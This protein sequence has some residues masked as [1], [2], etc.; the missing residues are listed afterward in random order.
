LSA[1]SLSAGSLSAGSPSVG[2][3]STAQLLRPAIKQNTVEFVLEALART[4][5]RTRADALAVADALSTLPPLLARENRQ[6]GIEVLTTLLQLPVDL[7]SPP[8][9]LIYAQR[10][11]PQL[12]AIFDQGLSGPGT[13]AALFGMLTL[14][15]RLESYDGAQ[16]V[17]AA[18]S[19]KLATDSYEWS[20]V[21][22][23][24]QPGHPQRFYVAEKLRSPLPEGFLGVAYLDLVNALAREGQFEQHPFDTGPGT[25][26]LW[27][28]L[29]SPDPSRFSWAESAAHALPFLSS[30]KREQFLQRA[31]QH[32][33]PEVRFAAVWAGAF[34]GLPEAVGW[35]QE[36]AKSPAYGKI[37]E[38]Y[39][40]ELQ[41]SEQVPVRFAAD[42][43]AQARLARWLSRPSEFGRPPDELELVETR[44]LDWPATGDKRRL[45]LIRFRYRARFA[46]RTDFVRVGCVGSTTYCHYELALPEK[47]PQEL[48]GIYLG[49]ELQQRR[50]PRAPDPNHLAAAAELLSF[51]PLPETEEQSG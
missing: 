31:L 37:V 14:F 49:W 30:P 40:K 43:E 33:A 2:S 3:P 19:R 20:Q 50:D 4:T 13:D 34:L 24:L 11:V 29:A 21:L 9:F 10:V 35:L 23:V 26:K 1:G 17:I 38:E 42:E 7:R 5:V 44:E 16:R 15:L 18:A 6:T 25:L 41:L 32:P 12:Y 48:W 22:S 28:W 46:G 36:F 8:V 39:A 45:W 51:P 27:D 47:T